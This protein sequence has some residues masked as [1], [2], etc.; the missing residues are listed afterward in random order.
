[1]KSLILILLFPVVCFGQKYDTIYDFGKAMTWRDSLRRTIGTHEVYAI[2]TG[3]NKPAIGIGSTIEFEIT[4]TTPTPD[5]S[6]VVMLCG[7]TTRTEGTSTGFINGRFTVDNYD[8]FV[9]WQFGYEVVIFNKH[10]LKLYPKYFDENKIP[11][12]KSTIVFQSIKL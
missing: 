7:D 9:W 6:R 4:T 1:M 11:I 5:M 3:G 2:P 12:S 10:E 8:C